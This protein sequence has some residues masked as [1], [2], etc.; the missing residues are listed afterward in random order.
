MDAGQREYLERRHAVSEWHGRDTR[1]RRVVAGFA[2]GGSEL[3]GWT[4]LRSRRDER[5]APAAL[6][7]LWSR[8]DP[9]E[10][11]LAVDIWECVSVA[12]AHDQLLEVLG[13]VQSDVIERHKGRNGIGDVEF[14]LGRTMALFVRVNVVVLLRNAGPKTVD[15]QPVARVIDEMLVRLSGTRT[16]PGRR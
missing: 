8:G 4:L 13:N 16:S 12:A 6:R 15:V 3:S 9:T 2:F 5:G 1:R 11:L 10:Q 14:T 7:T